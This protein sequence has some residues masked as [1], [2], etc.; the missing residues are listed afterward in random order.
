MPLESQL[1]SCSDAGEVIIASKNLIVVGVN[2][3]SVLFKSQRGQYIR[4]E[5]ALVRRPPQLRNDRRTS[6]LSKRSNSNS[7]LDGALVRCAFAKDMA[8]AQLLSC[9]Q[10][11]RSEDY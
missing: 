3:S 6:P 2:E 1:A 4:L 10:L 7:C 9:V 11:V 5:S 8:Q